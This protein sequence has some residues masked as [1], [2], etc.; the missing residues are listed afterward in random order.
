MG[1]HQQRGRGAGRTRHPEHDELRDRF[2]GLSRALGRKT[3]TRVDGERTI[4]LGAE[5]PRR[6][7][8]SGALAALASVATHLGLHDDARGLLVGALK[9]ARDAADQRTEA[10]TLHALGENAVESRAPEVARKWFTE[11]LE[12]RRRIGHRPGVCETLLALGQLCA[13]SGAVAAARPFLEEATELA[14][15]LEMPSIAALARA[16]SALLHARDG[17]PDRARAELEEARMA[18]AA[19]GPLSLAS[20]VEGMWFAALTARTLGDENAAAQHLAA[21]WVVLQD[22]AARMDPDERHA[23]LHETSPNRE[24][25]EAAAA[26]PGGSAAERAGSAHSE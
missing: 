11:A 24:I 21:A 14:P 15:A 25:A 1:R 4:L 9:A 19:P 26:L 10:S 18:F 5:L 8:E 23:F 16:T 13:L 17:H 22:I 20:R 3:E 12:L 6:L 7:R 2:L